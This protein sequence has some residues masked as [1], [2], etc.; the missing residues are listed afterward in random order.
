VPTASSFG[1]KDRYYAAKKLPAP[2]SEGFLSF[3]RVNAEV[4]QAFLAR[5]QFLHEN[6]Q[7][8]VTSWSNQLRE[9]IRSETGL[10]FSS[11][12]ERHS[13]SVHVVDGLP[14]PLASA[15]EEISDPLLWEI[16]LNNATLKTTLTGLDVVIKNF[17]ALGEWRE[18][19]PSP[20]T[21]D[22]LHNT[23]QLVANL[24]KWLESQSIRQR[25][26]SIDEDVLGAYFF[27]KGNIQIYWMAIYLVA[28]ILDVSV[29][30]LTI[31][32][33]A[34]ELV[35]AYT[36][37]GSDI[38]GEQWET[39]AFAEAELK[40]VEGLAQFY[41]AI[42]CKKLEGKLPGLSNAFEQLLSIQSPTYTAF[43]SWSTVNE[44]AGEIVRFSMIGARK[45]KLGSY[46]GFLEEMKKVRE[47]VGRGIPDPEASAG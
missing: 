39:N 33:L 15:F 37:V 26:Q 42:I 2:D 32:V 11:G 14:L 20:I 36:H 6:V 28:R 25:F 18:Q 27:R 47:R 10:K 46:K 3:S 44:R 8:T 9:L 30:G 12:N 1:N 35:H 4:R 19:N 31:A 29:A 40:I 16:V 24:I 23:R 41:T 5:H 22:E 21:L 45:K 34:H 38:D 17:E 7:R 13:V 43:R